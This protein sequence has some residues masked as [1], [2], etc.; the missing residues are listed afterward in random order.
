MNDHDYA[1][2]LKMSIFYQRFGKTTKMRAREFNT[3]LKNDLKGCEC[4]GF[5][6]GVRLKASMGK[7]LTFL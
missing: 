5:D 3:R 6:I 2:D 4:K 7:P 1:C